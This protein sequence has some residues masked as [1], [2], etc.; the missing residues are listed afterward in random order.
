M[1]SLDHDLDHLPRLGSQDYGFMAQ[2]QKRG[3]VQ[4]LGASASN[5]TTKKARRTAAESKLD[6]KQKWIKSQQQT[7]MEEEDADPQMARAAVY[8]LLVLED[9]LV[10]KV[11]TYKVLISYEVLFR[12]IQKPILD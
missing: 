10:S 9:Q 4:P 6:A 11:S 5:M 8:Y 1:S 2:P 7:M 12:S 3:A